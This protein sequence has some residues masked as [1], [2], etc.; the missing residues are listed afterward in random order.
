MHIQETGEKRVMG[1]RRQVPVITKDKRR[2]TCE[3]KLSQIEVAGEKSYIG[4]MHD[5][6][7][8]RRQ[9]CC[10]PAL[11]ISQELFGPPRF[12]LD[13]DPHVDSS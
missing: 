7:E 9:V 12:C 11:W 10:A 5:V 3:L 13:H 6:S 8:F 1:Q 2:L 4:L